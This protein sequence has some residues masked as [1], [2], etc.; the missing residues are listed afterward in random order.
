MEEIKLLSFWICNLILLIILYWLIIIGIA[1][2]VSICISW[3]KNVIEKI[4]KQGDKNILL[5]VIDNNN[6]RRY[7]GVKLN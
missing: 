2:P 5:S 1:I 4:I 3:L 7:V 6:R